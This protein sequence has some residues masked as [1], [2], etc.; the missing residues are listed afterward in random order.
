MIVLDTHTWIWNAVAPKRLSRA[1]R[2]TID[3]ATA[4]GISTISCW[5]VSFLAT[6]GR[7]R[8][9]RGTRAWVSA[10]LADHRM[11]PLPVSLDIALVAGGLS[12]LRDPADRIIYAT[13]VEHD[14]QLVSRD[15]RLHDLDP[16]RL[17]W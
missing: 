5:E 13:A 12:T 2:S 4:I 8:L 11:T 7:L 1:A 6:S 14:A 15:Q 10:A 3:R 17:V 9:D 16:K